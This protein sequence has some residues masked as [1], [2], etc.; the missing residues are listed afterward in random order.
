M[1]KDRPGTMVE[2]WEEEEV[3]SCD[4]ITVQE[5]WINKFMPTTY[6][7]Y[8]DKFSLR[9][10]SNEIPHELGIHGTT[11]VCT[12][13]NR[14]IASEDVECEDYL[15]T[16]QSITIKIKKNRLD[17]WLT[18]HNCYL[19]PPGENNGV[20][21]AEETLIKL[22]E[23]LHQYSANEQMVVGDLN[24]SHPQW[25][26]RGTRIRGPA[27]EIQELANR[28]D[29][30][31]ILP[32]ETITRPSDRIEGDFQGSTID[33]VWGT[34]SVAGQ[35]VR[36]GTVKELKFCS[37]HY[38][39]RTVLG[40]ETERY[41][42]PE[43]R[44]F[45]TMDTTKFL[46]SLECELRGLRRTYTT[47]NQ[48]DETVSHIVSALQTA[49]ADSTPWVKPLVKH[50]INW[51]PHCS[52]IIKKWKK[53][54]RKWK[55]TRDPED[56][57]K[58]KEAC[59]KKKREIQRELTQK[60][61][62]RVAEAVDA[63]KLWE[64]NRWASSRSTPRAT[65]TPPIRGPDGE[66]RK[67]C[68]EKA[69]V[70]EQALF[71]KPPEADLSDLTIPIFPEPLPF[72]IITIHEVRE[73][74]RRATADNAPGSDGIPNRIL[75][76]ALHLIE[77]P[78]TNLFNASLALHYW[79]AQLKEAIV[80]VIRKPS[81]PDYSNPKAYRPI[82][83][84]NTLSK[85]MEA[86]LAL[87]ISAT[88]EIHKLLPITHCGGRKA[89]SCEH[90]IHLLME[91]IHA[92]WRS[93]EDGVASLLLLDVSGAF[94][95]VSHLRLLH[96]VRKLGFHPNLVGWLGSYLRNR[97]ARLKLAEG[98]Q[99]EFPVDDGIPQGSPLSPILWLIY[100]HEILR[101][102]APEALKTG[103]ADDTSIMVTGTSTENNCHRLAEIH[104]ECESWAK[105]H[106]AKFAPSKYALIH[107]FKKPNS[108]I[109]EER[110][111]SL[112]LRLRGGEIQVIKPS[113]SERYLGVILDSGLTWVPH[114]KKA[115]GSAQKQIQALRGIAASTWGVNLEGMARLY[116]ATV[117]SKLLYAASAW[118]LPFPARG[119]IKKQEGI[120]KQLR[121]VQKTA[122]AHIS[123]AFRT[124]ALGALEVELHVPPIELRL[125]T[126][127]TNTTL[128]IMGSPIYEKISQIRTEI[129]PGQTRITIQSP[130]QT[131][132]SYLQ[133]KGHETWTAE[134]IEKHIPYV[135][136]PWEEPLFVQ[137]DKS[138]ERAIKTHDEIERTAGL[139]TVIAYTDGSE[140]GGRIGTACYIPR[141]NSSAKFYMGTNQESTVYSAELAGILIALFWTLS[142][143]NPNPRR[144][145]FHASQQ[146][147]Q[148]GPK[149]LVVF[150]DN[151]AAIQAMHRPKNGSGQT[152]LKQAMAKL[153]ELKNRGITVELRWI[154]SHIG[155]PGNERV[156]RL[157]KE[158]TGWRENRTD[159]GETA[160]WFSLTTTQRSAAFRTMKARAKEAWEAKWKKAPSG[161]H[162]FRLREKP[163]KSSLD[164]YKGLK[165]A[166][167]SILIQARTGKIATGD[168]LHFIKAKETADCS[169]G[170]GK[171]TVAHLVLSCPGFKELRY[172]IWGDKPPDDIRK[173][174]EGNQA[175]KTA[176]FLGRT[177][178][179]GQFRDVKQY[180]YE[181]EQPEAV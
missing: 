122:L 146:Q 20:P 181:E 133:R 54:E 168:Y 25:A 162:T 67:T 92:A 179:L 64:L 115:V 69:R 66:L 120:K 21:S 29:L 170:E 85:V 80:V 147:Q 17:T 100:G 143:S 2:W 18:I 44:N 178:I 49:I 96:T 75:K 22:D 74:V 93:G 155:I 16:L 105:K 7:P 10:P 3:H 97:T 63:P 51:T 150:V 169:C 32:P 37:D 5:P 137:I 109:D 144:S 113:N 156:D 114:V 165:R 148:N 123:G 33:L 71:A 42:S 58:W 70:F 72:P 56:H 126:I 34:P 89:S 78:L 43:K 167:S 172:D 12:Y 149:K 50:R 138:A 76:T 130:L 136:Y 28:Y 55:R 128:R 4:I 35:V 14:R 6:H 91:K 166:L 13:I 57:Q 108:V 81:K 132:E 79:P 104:E 164:L 171:E 39:V 77:T 52:E 163:H 119:Y 124:T 40:Y 46:N 60:H 151:Q 94:D 106:A 61:R 30:H 121:N 139:E 142:T 177:R 152:Y 15:P 19:V 140:I 27:G 174:L 99:D 180:I 95:N 38:P 31:L 111:R 134:K 107:F 173:A 117:L 87:R 125:Q 86:I 68:Q 62:E 131:T 26:G 9:W 65:F 112:K 83:L 53:A 127:V 103:Y 116:Q 101:I 176:R 129:P 84:L 135:K 98:L 59:S 158:A 160:R 175:T 102:G 8:P 36:C 24:A 47:Q 157:A 154:P 161:R 45:R 88:A 1:R 141:W 153:K 23:A 73:A 118:Y 159:L 82:A 110:F 145:I 90:A 41:E 48:L 11:R